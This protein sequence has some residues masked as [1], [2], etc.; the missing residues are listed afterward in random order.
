MNPHHSRR[1]F[2]KTTTGGAVAGAGFSFL[3]KLP[4][5]SAAEAAAADSKIVRLR[6][7]IE[8][9]VRL[10][11]DTPRDRVIEE[12][13]RRI[14][15]GLSYRE[16]LAALLLAGVRNVQPR[17]AVG[18]KF[19]AVL[20][21]NAAHLA[22]VSG[23]DSDR[24]LPI[25]WV[26]DD[27]KKSQARDVEEGD[28]TMAPVPENLVPPPQKARQAFVEAMDRWDEEAADAAVAGLYR[29]AG[30]QEIF[31]LFVPYAARDLRSIGHKAIYLANAWRT[32]QVMGWEHAEPV[33]R[34]LAY[35]LLNRGDDPNPAEND[36]EQDRPWR[37]GE[38]LAGE[39]PAG[40]QQGKIESGTTTSLMDTFRSGSAEEASAQ[41]AQLF[42]DGAAPQSI[43][44]G[45]F[46]GASELMLR[47][48]AIPALHAVTTTNAMHYLYQTCADDTTRRR[49]LLQNAAFLP[50]FRDFMHS[51]GDVAELR[52]DTLAAA[53]KGADSVES[54][55]GGSGV[56]SARKVMAYAT[57]ETRAR[58]LIGEVRRR[59][60]LKGT[61]AHHYKFSSAVLEDYFQV[62]PVWRGRLLACA[63]QYLPSGKNNPLVERIR[64]AL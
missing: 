26:I 6:S 38:K 50:L 45:L 31:E 14:R 15:D 37:R 47:Q 35:A 33:L 3:E 21:V 62:S 40:W 29:S 53:E 12:M 59:I 49:L 51:R 5:V 11:E 1:R 18:F 61:D 7:E 24:W 13:A 17:P 43:I 39:I 63:P 25:L 27:F 36:L 22:S 4:L 56:E 42:K 44:D 46:V 58:E 60:F 30:A 41:V 54:A 2:L 23:P 9:L 34:S 64:Q 28:W 20:V 55:L 48:P 57:D 10:L 32:L 8:P 19:H 16:V 52:I